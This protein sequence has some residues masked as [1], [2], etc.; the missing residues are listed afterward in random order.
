MTKVSP[1]NERVKK[2]TVNATNY[3]TD[4]LESKM[5]Q[6]RNCVDQDPLASDVAS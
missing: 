6:Y 1:R 4:A 3:P 2:T 5:I